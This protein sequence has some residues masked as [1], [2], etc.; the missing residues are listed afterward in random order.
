MRAKSKFTRALCPLGLLLATAVSHHSHA[1]TPVEDAVHNLA[2]GCY[3][4]QSP[5]NGK[6]M[7]RYHKGGALDNGLG[8]VF[9]ADNKDSA[10]KFFLKPARFFDYMLRDVD[11][12][13]LATHLPLEVSS[14][15]YAGEFAEWHIQAVDTDDG[16]QYR[17]HANKL[18]RHTLKHH[19]SNGGGLYLVDILN[20]N[21]NGAEDQ[22]KLV[23]TTGCAPFPEADLN[24][25]VADASVPETTD[26]SQPVRGLADLH[27]HISSYEFIG[28]RVMHGYPFHPHGIETALNDSSKIHGPSGA[29]DLIGNLVG[30]GD[31]G[32]RYDTAGYPNFPFWPKADSLTHM[33]SYYRW[34]ERANKAG[35]K[36]MVNHLVENKVLCKIQST[37]NPVSWIG[38]NS[39]DTMESIDLQIRRLYEMQEY[40]DAQ[41]G[42]PGKGFFRLVKTAAE[43][44]QVIAQ[45]KLAVF[46]AVEASEMFG[47][48]IKSNPCSKEHI[49]NGLKHLKEK[50]IKS[51][52]L[53]HRFDN[54]LS[55][56]IIESGFMNVG[57]WLSSGRFFQ[58][59]TCSNGKPMESGFPLI[60]SVPVLKDIL[61]KFGLNPQYAEGKQC[62]LF[63]LSDLGVYAANRMMDMGMV[64]ETDHMSDRSADAIIKIAEARNYSGLISS[65]NHTKIQRS[66]L[67]KL[68][69]MLAHYNFK[70]SAVN[71]GLNNYLN[72]VEKFDFHPGVALG[73][74]VGGLG[75]QAAPRGENETQLA[76]PFLSD[77]GRYRFT[78]QKTGNRIFD[79][80]S[81]GMAHYG[82]MAD[83]IADLKNIASHRVYE[84][85]M[86]SAEAYLQM[87]ERVE[88]GN[89]SQYHN[90]QPI[91]VSLVDDRAHKCI[92]IAGD[93]NNVVQGAELQLWDCQ[94]QS[95]DQKWFYDP[96]KKQLK[97][98]TNPNLCIDHGARFK[99]SGNVVLWPCSVSSNQRWVFEA[100]AYRA[101][102]NTDY[103]LTALG[104]GNGTKVKLY[105]YGAKQE[106]TWRLRVDEA[107]QRWV[108]MRLGNSGL[109]L[110]V[111]NG[112]SANATK[113][114]AWTC[115]GANAQRWKYDGAKQH[116]MS[117]VAPNK[118]L[119]APAGNVDNHSRPQIW[120]CAYYSDGSSHIN[121]RFTFDGGTIRSMR[122]G[123]TQVLDGVGVKQGD[124]IIFHHAHGGQNQ[125]FNAEIHTGGEL[126]QAWFLLKDNR[127][128]KCL[129]VPGSNNVNGTKLSVWDCHGGHNQQWHFDEK[130]KQLK[131]R[132]GKCL[133]TTGKSDNHTPLQLWTC[134]SGLAHINM[135]FEWH[136]NSLRTLLNTNQAMDASGTNNGA[137]VILHHSN[138]SSNQSWNFHSPN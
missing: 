35:L 61:D 88:A 120:D 115:N 15:T 37:V 83:H 13:Y 17:L 76:Y 63:G 5:E 22:F 71:G 75:N 59:Q 100:G 50:G 118:C 51:V 7:Q 87:L 119:D 25:E 24:M 52:F 33:Q 42:G 84:G 10:S 105:R 62:N 60:G 89:T 66:R 132:L 128:G 70:A 23:E 90:P 72:E 45:G 2:Q 11:G 80:N 91:A 86:K 9:S 117:A 96:A 6:F 81:D 53:S 85:L 28:G 68:G 82:L 8:Y 123:K 113:L 122:H 109:C 125:Q 111:I 1:S 112:A 21:N 44:R 30:Y 97:N 74:D 79:L 49:D 136:G 40:V 110:D 127:S 78:Q 26:P 4:V 12:R 130:T 14:G 73:S 108:E 56:T 34:I 46:F 106:Q 116:L 135:R 93:D 38:H 103:A 95:R 99:N 102:S 133:D 39:C 27:T 19:Y 20:P 121:Q 16:Y 31:P 104:T 29:L 64:I 32:F 57:Q 41:A 92:D 43:A 134:S 18:L 3:S 36:L 48:G 129:D 131:N 69:G 65:H 126:P 124:P 58:T 54:Q 138:G 137:A 67:T 55:S 47:C 94:K 98:L 77:N 114:R 101:E 107:Q